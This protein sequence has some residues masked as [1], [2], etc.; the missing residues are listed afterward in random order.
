MSRTLYAKALWR[1]PSATLDD[2]REAVTT[3]EDTERIARRVLGGAH[4]THSGTL[5][6]NCDKRESAPAKA[7]SSPSV[8]PS[9]RWRRGMRKTIHMPTPAAG[10]TARAGWAGRIG[11]LKDYMYR[12]AKCAGMC[13]ALGD[14]AA[15]ALG[16]LLVDGLVDGL[17]G[18]SS[19]LSSTWV[20]QRGP[21]ASR[22][23]TAA[24]V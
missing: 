18:L 21:W 11:K 20:I 6:A 1:D 22:A 10:E 2:L 5:R 16:A 8:R 23:S 13:R 9:R 24:R 14:G 4:P 15:P 12:G 19:A 3:L 7:T 17:V